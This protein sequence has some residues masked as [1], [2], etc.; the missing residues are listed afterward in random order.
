L[1]AAFRIHGAFC[2]FVLA[3]QAQNGRSREAQGV[4]LL[5][6]KAAFEDSRHVH[7]LAA[8]TVLDL[9]AAGG[10]VGN[11]DG[12]IRGLSHGRQQ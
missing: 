3:I 9:V 2:A 4:G 10:T 7:G 12:V 6:N 8:R 5:P 1:T 11:Q